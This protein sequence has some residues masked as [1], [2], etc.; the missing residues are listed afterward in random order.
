MGGFSNDSVE[1]SNLLNV[2]MSEFKEFVSSR[3]LLAFPYLSKDLIKLCL[4]RSLRIKVSSICIDIVDK[5]NK[6]IIRVSRRLVHYL[7][8]IISCFEY[9]FNSAL[10]VV[11]VGYDG[12]YNLVD[13]SNVRYHEVI[14]YDD[15]PILTPS[16]VEPYVTTK[17]YLDYGRLKI[18]DIVLDLGCYSGLTSIT[19][20]KQVGNEG[21]IISVEP[22]DINYQCTLKNVGFN[23]RINGLQNITTLNCAISSVCGLMEF[24]SEGSMGSA[25]TGIV[26]RFRGKVT[27][28]ECIDLLTLANRQSLERIDFIKM[29]IEGSEVEV[30]KASEIFFRK[31][32]PRLVI[33][34][35]IVDGV[36]CDREVMKCLNSYGYS[37]WRIEQ[38]GV[39]LPLL[40]AE[41]SL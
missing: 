7:P 15:F 35:H 25:P 6:R 23:S 29:D 1:C 27:T 34:P 17:Q 9:Y 41:C 2:I 36:L 33:E 8:D 31:Y 5:K 13:F 19:F 30:I 18:G 11:W 4:S 21:R 10:P 22:D 3:M 40:Y 39:V 12:E 26:G 20:S 32:K 28:V 38:T 37:C 16:L 14:G 24:S